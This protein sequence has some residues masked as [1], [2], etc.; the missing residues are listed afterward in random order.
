MI[1]NL[2]LIIEVQQNVEKNHIVLRARRK[3]KT[4]FFKMIVDLIKKKMFNVF[5]NI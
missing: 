5:E 4:S 3:R 2:I 1:I